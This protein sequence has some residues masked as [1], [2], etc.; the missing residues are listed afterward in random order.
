[1]P[2]IAPHTTT[3]HYQVIAGKTPDWIKDAPV[4]NVQALRTAYE[5]APDTLRAACLRHPDI[6]RALA[7]EHERFLASKRETHKLFSPLPNLQTFAEQRLRE[8]IRHRFGLDI[9]VGKTYL[10]DAIGHAHRRQMGEAEPKQ[11]VRP[12]MHYALQNFEVK[13]TEAGAMDVETPQARSVILDHQGYQNGPPFDN[14]VNIAPTAFAALC[15]ELDIGGQYHALIDSIYYPTPDNTLANQITWTERLDTLAQLEMSRFRQSLHCACLLGHVSQATYDAMLATVLDRMTAELPAQATFAFLTLW[16]IELTGLVLIQ[17]PGTAKVV[18]YDNHASDAAIQ[19]YD[20]LSDL[21]AALRNAIQ[22]DLAVIAR[23]IPDARKAELLLKVQDHLLPLTFTLRNVYERIPDPTADLPVTPRLFRYSF[24]EEMLYQRYTRLRDDALFHAVPTVAMD[25]KT[26]KDRLAY[27]E[28]I[29]FAGLNL[30]G[31]FIPAVGTMMLAVTVLN[32]GYEVYEGIDAW[33]ND[34]RDQAMSYLLDVLENMALIAATQAVGHGLKAELGETGATGHEPL[35]ASKPPTVQTPS[36]VE[37]LLEV[38]LPDG[39]TRLWNP[40][41]TPYESQTPIPAG[42]SADELGL[43]RKDGRIWLRLEDKTY[44]LK[45][46]SKNGL[47]KIEIPSGRSG[48]EPPLSHNG[49]GAWL[50]ALDRPRQWNGLRLMRRLGPLSEVLDDQSLA[51]ALHVSGLEQGALRHALAET[52][53]MPALLEDTLLRFALD[54]QVTRQLPHQP[55]WQREAAFHKRYGQLACNQTPEAALLRRVYP[56]LPNAVVEELLRNATADELGAL[57]VGKVPK[58]LGEEARQYQQQVR[59][60]RAYEGLYLSSV[61]NVDTERLILHTLTTLDSWPSN[62]A[63]ELHEGRF[64]PG[65]ID[66]V[67]PENAQ[68][69]WII[70]RYPN[71]YAVNTPFPSNPN[72]TLHTSIFSAL[73]QVSGISAHRDAN[74][75]R[76]LV[77]E[78]PTLPRGVLRKKLGMQRRMF[79]SPMRLAD[80]RIGYPLSP[81]VHDL[82]NV[83]RFTRFARQIDALGFPE[84]AADWLTNAL[85][86]DHATD[87]EIN[88]AILRLPAPDAALALQASVTAWRAEPVQR[89]D[90]RLGNHSRDMIESG[91][92]WHWVQGARGLLDE[93][94][95]RLYLHSTFLE[96]FPS[97]LPVSFTESVRYLHLEDV[98][99]NHRPDAL[100]PAAEANWPFTNLFGQFPNLRVLAIERPSLVPATAE[101]TGRLPLINQYFAHLNELHLVNQNL[102]LSVEDIALLATPPALDY[103]ELS[104]NHLAPAEAA[105]GHWQLQFL[106]LDRMSLTAWPAWLDAG[107]L[108]RIQAVSL[109]DNALQALPRFLEQNFPADQATIITLERN[110]LSREQVRSLAFSEDEHA[111]RFRFN[112]TI[113]QDLQQELDH[114]GEQRR[115]LRQSLNDWL[116]A[117]PASTSKQQMAQEFSTFWELRSRGIDELPLHIIDQTVED[118]PDGLPDFFNHT[119]DS[120]ILEGVDASM[121]QF[122]RLLSRYPNLVTLAL[123][124]LPAPLPSLPA[125][126]AQLPL[127]RELELT[128]LGLEINDAS[129]QLLARLPSLEMLDLSENRLSPMLRGPFRFTRQLRSLAL[130]QVGMSAWPDWLYSLMPLDLLDLEGNLISSLPAALLDVPVVDNTHTRISLTGNPLDAATR[131][132]VEDQ[133]GKLTLYLNHGFRTG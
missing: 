84:Q 29:A 39:R 42:V 73:A 119:V 32:L 105:P 122:D 121:Q 93:Q 90:L 99:F 59:L 57:T 6:A 4:Q 19:E 46:D 92:W 98:V 124:E 2:D 48:H 11:F 130:S 65:P 132:R 25:A 133:D 51:Q 116:N 18:L 13:S 103:L 82:A 63:L 15:R 91:L 129:L 114:L 24:V 78:A 104:G 79:R 21:K 41:L 95:A 117:H 88:Q 1:M 8:G 118:L 40:D 20:S 56:Q 68:H 5:I 55:Q 35:D 7:Q 67:G 120:L 49:A 81:L 66:S 107:T 43:Y 123:Y 101:L 77:Q 109:S 33:A 86:E 113:T 45:W 85:L 47:Y 36:F 106:G 53:R 10:Y 37:E 87:A 17:L 115:H 102:M 61:R 89:V 125:A 108:E 94:E 38:E 97:Q 34:D 30:V 80:G 74:A 127:L 110:P 76:R 60:T 71:G 23:C 26:F 69:R 16:R 27:Y 52:Q 128:N 100:I 72:A 75:L 50:H 22:Q 12:L 131:Q 28:S 62:L 126:I 14:V 3:S 83:D 96:E 70:T 112:L 31:M 9:D 44:V 54:Q 111:R 64:T 58:H